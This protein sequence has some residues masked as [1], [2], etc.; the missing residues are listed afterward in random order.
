MI[1]DKC[2]HEW[3]RSTPASYNIN[4]GSIPAYYYCNKCKTSM[5]APEVFQLEALENQ[6]ETL[7]HLKGFEKNIAIIAII[8]SFIALL[9]SMF[10]ESFFG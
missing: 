2:N 8:I 7:K 1:T 9:I 10:G 3:I 6:N 5:T 4:T